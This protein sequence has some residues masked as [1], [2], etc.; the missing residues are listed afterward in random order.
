MPYALGPPFA[1][2]ASL[3]TA[4]EVVLLKIVKTKTK[5]KT[6]YFVSPLAFVYPRRDSANFVGKVRSN[7]SGTEF[8]LFD[9]G[10]NPEKKEARGAAL[11]SLRIEMGAVTY[12]T[13]FKG[14]K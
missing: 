14:M 3:I 4:V 5:T 6:V 9:N 11:E 12:E 7:Y 1:V 10:I 13:N 8:S 2:H